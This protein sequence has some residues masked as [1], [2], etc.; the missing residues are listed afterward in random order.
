MLKVFWFRNEKGWE[1]IGITNVDVGK[2]FELD[3]SITPHENKKIKEFSSKK[4]VD[5]Y[6][7][8]IENITDPDGFTH[9]VPSIKFTIKTS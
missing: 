3:K 1:R 9:K 5:Q 2:V 7:R 4:L 6:L 8:E